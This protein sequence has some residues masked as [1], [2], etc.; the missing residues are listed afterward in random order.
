MTARVCNVKLEFVAGPS[1]GEVHVVRKRRFTLGASEDA[2][3]RYEAER[4]LQGDDHILF[5]FDRRGKL[6]VTG[7]VGTGSGEAHTI[8]RLLSEGDVLRIGATEI[9]AVEIASGKGDGGTGG[10]GEGGHGT[11]GDA[12]VKC[13]N[14]ACG[15]LNEAGRTWCSTCGRDL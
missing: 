13:G 14:P 12:P 8:E 2:D 4:L 6:S 5:E 10:Q 3:V 9:L 15:A 11:D 1:D 7:T